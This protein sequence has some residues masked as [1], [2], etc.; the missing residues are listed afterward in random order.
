MKFE[1]ITSAGYGEF[2]EQPLLCDPALGGRFG[3]DD[4]AEH[5]SDL[6]ESVILFPVVTTTWI[7]QL[8]MS[9][10]DW[11]K[12]GSVSVFS[13]KCPLGWCGLAESDHGS[14]NWINIPLPFLP[15][16][17]LWHSERYTDKCCCA[18]QTQ[19]EFVISKSRNWF[20][21]MN[22]KGKTKAVARSFPYVR[23]E[24]LQL[25][26]T[27]YSQAWLEWAQKAIFQGS[28]HKVWVGCRHNGNTGK[29]VPI[30]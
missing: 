25:S 27:S 30:F 28:C 11:V 26:A 23:S 17:S 4:L 19:R 21:L 1:Q 29:R 9:W 7:I 6:S 13:M 22:N 3:L 24:P 15:R 5:P 20:C 8:S 12:N 2:P 14:V 10:D 16:S 18:E